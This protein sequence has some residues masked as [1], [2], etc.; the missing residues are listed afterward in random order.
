MRQSERAVLEAK[1]WDVE[2]RMGGRGAWA[3]EVLRVAVGLRQEGIWNSTNAGGRTQ[4]QKCLDI[5]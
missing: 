3:E 5:F 1:S 2:G 4:V